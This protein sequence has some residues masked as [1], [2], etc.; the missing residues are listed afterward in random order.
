MRPLATI[1]WL[2]IRQEDTVITLLRM[3]GNTVEDGLAGLLVATS[4]DAR[5]L[6]ENVIEDQNII[7]YLIK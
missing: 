2:G 7:Q 5:Y 4:A 3:G 6:Q 1:K